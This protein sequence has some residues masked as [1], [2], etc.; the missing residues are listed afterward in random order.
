VP[1]MAVS[2]TSNFWNGGITFT[3]PFD[4]CRSGLSTKA[5]LLQRSRVEY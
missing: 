2:K 4:V 1:E 3:K 5:Q